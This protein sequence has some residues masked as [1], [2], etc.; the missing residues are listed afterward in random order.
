MDSGSCL[1]PSTTDHERIVV[2]SVFV[3]WFGIANGN[4]GAATLSIHL[5]G[6]ER[7]VDGGP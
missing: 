5:V 6:V 7:A 2:W 3:V 1:D 4:A